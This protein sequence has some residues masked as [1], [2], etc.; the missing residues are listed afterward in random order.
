[1]GIVGVYGGFEGNV[2]TGAGGVALRAVDPSFK[3]TAGLGRG[4]LGRGSRLRGTRLAASVF[5]GSRLAG[6]ERVLGLGT[7][8][9]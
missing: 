8:T 4:R 5:H 9:G 3:S 1:L 7:K 2:W 6:I